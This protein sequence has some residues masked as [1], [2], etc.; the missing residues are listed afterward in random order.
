[1]PR[2]RSW[3]HHEDSHRGSDA[4]SQPHSSTPRSHRTYFS[5]AVGALVREGFVQLRGNQQHDAHTSNIR[6][7][8]QKQMRNK[9]SHSG[10]LFREQQ[11]LVQSRLI[12]RNNKKK[13]VDN[14]GHIEH[15]YSCWKGA[16]M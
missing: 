6:A 4:L 9:T 13:Y 5:D 3:W 2:D 1:M 11:R 8:F 16:Q 14:S 12:D 7:W 10:L 15:F